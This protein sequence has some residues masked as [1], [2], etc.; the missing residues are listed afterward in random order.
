MILMTGATG[1]VGRH[2][3]NR[4][5]ADGRAVRCAVRGGGAARR[6][7]I[8]GAEIAAADIMEP[9]SL[10]EAMSGVATAINLVGIIRE[11]PRR[12]VTFENLHW[13]GARN[14]A[15][16]ARAAGVK[17]IIQM[18]A[19]GSRPGAVSNYHIYKYKGERAVIE[20]GAP[21]TIF[22]P[23]AQMGTDGEF[24]RMMFDMIKK[25]PVMPVFG[26]GDYRMQPMDV[27]DTAAF[28]AAAVDNPDAENKIFE[29]AGPE[30]FTYLE[31]LE[32]FEKA[33]GVKRPKIFIPGAAAGAMVS[34]MRLLPKPPIT[35]DQYI[36][37]REDNIA[38]VAP[39]SAALGV[40]PRPIGPVLEL[41]AR[42][43]SAGNT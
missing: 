15:E 9:A 21:Y 22:R 6:A 26:S 17:R 8:P 41:A 29:L 11:M 1:F 13:L 37:L 3:L 31:L 39:A 33:L 24:T 32:K 10:R 35:R 20:S 43:S 16:A 12:G 5:L 2:L 23:S 14:F 38:D 7:A 25:M 30:V 4:L 40:H 34:L 27:D 18:S 19:L 36:M 28:F 42:G